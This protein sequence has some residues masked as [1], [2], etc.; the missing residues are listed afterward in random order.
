MDDY[1][2]RYDLDGSNFWKA[3]NVF[4]GPAVV[5]AGAYYGF[6]EGSHTRFYSE[7]FQAAV[8]FLP[9]LARTY[10]S[11]AEYSLCRFNKERQNSIGQ[12]IAGG[13]FGGIIGGTISATE[14]CIAYGIGN[15]IGGICDI[16]NNIRPPF[17]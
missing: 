17:L 9:V 4:L 3:A 12:K 1:D 16:P 11:I 2:Y 14:F 13:F 7:N 15:I 8:M 5:V 6:C 10:S